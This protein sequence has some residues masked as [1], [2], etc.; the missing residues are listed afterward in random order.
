MRFPAPQDLVDD[1]LERGSLFAVGKRPLASVDNGAPRVRDEEPE[2]IFAAA[3]SG[4]RVS[5]QI[6]KNVTERR[7]RQPSETLVLLDRQQL[8]DGHLPEPT[9]QLNPRLLPHTDICLSSTPLRH[10]RQ[11]QWEPAQLGKGVDA[12]ASSSRL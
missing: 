12:A 1:R 5:L 8:M 3:V 10:E 6:E 7:R 4:K 11:R 9:V 2:E